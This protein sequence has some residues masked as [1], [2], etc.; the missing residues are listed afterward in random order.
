MRFSI[1][2]PQEHLVNGMR[3]LGYR[4]FGGPKGGEWS[5]VK[6]LARGDY[7]RFHVYVTQQNDM[8]AM[9]LHVDQKKPSYEGA[10]AHTGEY[11]G[12]LVEQEA[13]RIK[14]AL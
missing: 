7:P 2:K 13:E 14:R 8:L 1:K 10:T 9:N 3:G 5:F 4:A 12:P 11:D 6:S